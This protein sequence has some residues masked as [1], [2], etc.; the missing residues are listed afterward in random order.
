VKRRLRVAFFATG[1][2]L[3]SIGTALKEGE[4]YDSNRYTVHGMLRAWASRRSTWAWCAM[5]RRN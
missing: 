2:E 1:D 5:T 3:A 4:I